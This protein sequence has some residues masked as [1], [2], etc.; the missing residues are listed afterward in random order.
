MTEKQ[1]EL[2][3]DGTW[4]PIRVLF[5]CLGNICR[6]PLAEAVFRHQVEARGWADRF[7][8]D[9]AGTSGWHRGAPP[10]SRSAQVARR[11]GITLTGGSR[12]VVA[13]DLRRFHYVIAMDAE[14]EAALRELQAASGGAAQVH[15][16][17]EFEPRGASLDVPD[18]YYGGPRGFEEV[19]DIVERACAG[20]L[21]HV[22]AEHGL[23]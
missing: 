5:V 19:H 11:R 12:K 8:I 16:L 3:G 18:P 17:R 13:A 15:R 6:S 7:E 14:N 4:A 2:V 9:S 22:A 23:G 10:D 1:L 21:A 20:L